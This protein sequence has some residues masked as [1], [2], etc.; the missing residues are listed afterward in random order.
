MALPTIVYSRTAAASGSSD[1]DDIGVAIHD[2]LIAAGW[3]IVYADSDAIGGGSSSDPAWDKTPATNVLAG[4]VVYQMPL[5][6]HTTQW[7]LKFSLGWG[8]STARVSMRDVTIGDTHDGSGGVSGGGTI[9]VSAT[10][11]STYG[12]EFGISASEDGLAFF[13]TVPQ[14][15]KLFIERLRAWDETVT[16]DVVA[17]AANQGGGFLHARAGVGVVTSQA[18]VVLAGMHA[19]ATMTHFGSGALLVN[20]DGDEIPIVGPFWPGANPFYGAPR[21]FFFGPAGDYNTDADYDRVVDGGARTYHSL[22]TA[23]SSY[24]ANW[25]MATE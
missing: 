12:S 20:G 6:D 10:T 21:L 7:F 1:V 19:S 15:P 17:Y 2:A 11:A 22:A 4:T 18:P 8:T 25:M 3:S 23:A 16:D 14:G 9:S 5:N 24:W 13:C